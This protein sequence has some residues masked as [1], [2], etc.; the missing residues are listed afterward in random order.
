M[1]ETIN[2]QAIV[3]YTA[4]QMYA[5]VNDVQTYPDYLP[6]CEA[7]D[8]LHQEPTALEATVHFGYKGVKHRFTTANTMQPNQE[9]RMQLVEGP[10]SDFRGCWQFL[11]LGETGCKVVFSLHF[12]FKNR[13]LSMAFAKVFSLVAHSMVQAFT[14]RAA[15]V[16]AKTPSDPSGE[17]HDN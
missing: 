3:P 2:Q 1:S 8:L 12:A 17:A 13:L 5:L 7:V 9:I 14:D 11:P 15:V 4:A 6:W 16:Y 10:F